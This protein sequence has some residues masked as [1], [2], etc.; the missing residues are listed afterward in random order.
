M[1]TH[2]SL[3]PIMNEATPP[4]L[5][6][7]SCCTQ[8]Q[9]Y[10]KVCVVQYSQTSKQR[11]CSVISVHSTVSNVA[12]KR[13]SVQKGISVHRFSRAKNTFGAALGGAMS[14]V[15]RFSVIYFNLK[16]LYYSACI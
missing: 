4:H 16:F 1:T 3:V 13:N 6:M 10:L 8:G 15:L 2:L 12:V 11:H 14:R 5:H 7:S 9:I